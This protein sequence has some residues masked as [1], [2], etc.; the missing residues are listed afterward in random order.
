MDLNDLNKTC[1][2]NVK[3]LE[4]SETKKNRVFYKILEGSEWTIPTEGGGIAKLVDISMSGCRMLINDWHESGEQLSITILSTPGN[5]EIIG[6]IIS[7]SDNTSKAN[8][9]YRTELEF[10]SLKSGDVEKIGELECFIDLSRVAMDSRLR[11]T[12]DDKIAIKHKTVPFK[13]DSDS[14][15]LHVATPHLTLE[16]KKE[17]EKITGLKLHVHYAPFSD[18]FSAARMLY[19]D[20]SGTEKEGPPLKVVSLFEKVMNEA[21]LRK[22]SDLHIH[23]GETAKVRYRVDGTLA[24]GAAINRQVSQSIVSRIKVLAGMDIAETR[25]AQDGQFEWKG[26]NGKQVDVR[27]ASVPTVE[28]EHISLRLMN[29]ENRPESLRELGMS[30]KQLE[31]FRKAIKL[32]N[33][34]IL[35]AGPTG[36]GKTTTLYAA[37]REIDRT[38]NHIITVEDPVE[39]RFPNITQIE[40]H[41]RS[42]V[43]SENILRSILR[44]DPDV[45]VMGEIRD[46]ASLN[47]SLKSSLTG[48]MVM[49]S[50]HANDMS[51]VPSRLVDMGAQPYLASSTLTM[52]IAQRL[53]RKLCPECKIPV[54]LRERDAK[55]LGIDPEMEIFRP[56]IC[57]KCGYSGY[58]G[59]IGVYEILP[60]T[61]AIR[62]AVVDDQRTMLIKEEI[63][64]NKVQTMLSRAGELVKEGHTSVEEALRVLS[65]FE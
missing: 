30:Q 55:L 64:K 8:F 2:I 21:V 42:K 25:N 41:G 24:M 6:Q 50:I 58:V 62:E 19:G 65:E 27:V 7:I 35:V 47:L 37:I 36:S 18:V 31:D 63:E 14:K 1:I 59:R 23:P 32:P 61:P 4:E 46:K 3:D 11:S 40:M 45:L 54:R 49:G 57:E 48:H 28:G 52:V 33:G 26:P 38:D 13:I 22:A 34:L 16:G 12:L 44:H 39:H 51:L 15:I 17:M 10:P 56:G 53:L 29:P 43:A 5:I 9:K 60:V 20:F